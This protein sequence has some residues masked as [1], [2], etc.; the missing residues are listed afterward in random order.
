M[1]SGASDLRAGR[2]TF[3]RFPAGWYHACR[4]RDL[5][6]GPV[7]VAVGPTKFV[8]FRA[9]RGRAAVLD[10]RCS[11]MGADLS[12]GCASGGLLHCPL[13]DWRYD[14]DGRPPVRSRKKL[15]SSRRT[16]ALPVPTSIATP[17]ATPNPARRKAAV[18]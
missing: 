2:A 5:E 12:L 9:E 13:H 3:P 10:A 18:R 15:L 14:G 1:S 17:V 4:S 7:A 16:Q 6:R 8:A 11:H